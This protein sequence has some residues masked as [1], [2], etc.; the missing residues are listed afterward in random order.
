M[1]AHTH[2]YI[3]LYID[4]CP[5]LGAFGLLCPFCAGETTCAD[6]VVGSS[7]GANVS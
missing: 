4:T 3:N 2:T 6:G 7:A 1:Y 5:T